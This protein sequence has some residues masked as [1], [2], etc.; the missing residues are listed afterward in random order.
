[1][2][3][4]LGFLLNNKKCHLEEFI[5]LG[6]VWN[7]VSWSV[8]LKQVREVKVRKAA[9]KLFNSDIVKCREV[10]A[11]LGKSPIQ[12]YSYTAGKRFGENYSMKILAACLSE[13]DY[14]KYMYLSSEARTEL[15]YWRNLPDGLS[16]PIT[17]P[18]SSLT[19]TTDATPHS[20]GIYF[21]GLLL[22]DKIPEQYAGF[23]A[24]M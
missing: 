17:L 9:E 20:Y 14:N 13:A 3:R 4:E 18:Q 21:D 23:S 24:L 11:F 2:L 10:A 22:S 16:L 7:T 19:V 12:C 6:S 8:S 1:M 15:Q 5:Y